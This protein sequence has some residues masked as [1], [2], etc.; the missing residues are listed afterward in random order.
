MSEKVERCQ[1]QQE[2]MQ[3]ISVR[4]RGGTGPVS[5]MVRLQDNRLVRCH[6][7]HLRPRVEG[8]TTMMDHK[9]ANPKLDYQIFLFKHLSCSQSV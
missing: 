2:S 1:L 4:V 9:R 6:L 5:F 7:D 8:E 3:E